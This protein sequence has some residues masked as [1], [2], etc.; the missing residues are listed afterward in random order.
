MTDSYGKA[1]K[2]KLLEEASIL[3][4]LLDNLISNWAMLLLNHSPH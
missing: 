2:Y 1:K 3:K 4:I